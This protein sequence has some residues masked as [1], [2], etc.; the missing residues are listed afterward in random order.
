MEVAKATHRH[1]L[2]IHS[3]AIVAFFSCS[4]RWLQPRE[5]RMDNVIDRDRPE[6]REKRRVDVLN[7]ILHNK[8]LMIILCSRFNESS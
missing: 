5:Q 2:L 7:S 8:E 3:P 4:D 6:K 1:D